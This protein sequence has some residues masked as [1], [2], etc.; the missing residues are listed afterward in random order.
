MPKSPN[1]LLVLLLTVFLGL[2]GIHRFYLGKIGTGILYFLTAGLGGV[3]WIIDIFRAAAGGF[4][5]S[6]GATGT[7]K[8]PSRGK[9]KV[10]ANKKAEL[11]FVADSKEPST[12]S[13][14]RIVVK[15][16]AGTQIEMPLHFIDHADHEAIA[17]YVQG[18]KK[19][20]LDDEGELTARF[21]LIP[22]VVDYWGG[23]CYHF[24][25]PSGVPAFEA[26]DYFNESFELITKIIDDTTST[27]TSHHPKLAQG[28]F[29]FDVP[30]RLYY[31]WVES[32]DE[33]DNV[34]G[35]IEMEL[36]DPVLRLRD[37]LEVDVP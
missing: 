4:A 8:S 33:D 1:Y 5:Q 3:G 21:R 16:S 28:R 37:P 23:T 32:V 27:L 22:R 36:D 6:S 12:D 13:Q 14:N 25:T 18:R 34:T 24:E 19:G 29:A 7:K 17:R 35:E 31:Q 10:K 2:L 15:L 20:E 11:K 26:R 9:A 30:I